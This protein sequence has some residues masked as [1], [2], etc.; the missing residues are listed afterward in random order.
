MLNLPVVV[1]KKKTIDPVPIEL[2]DEPTYLKVKS[3]QPVKLIPGGPAVHVKLQWNG[4]ESLIRGN[5]RAGSS[6]P[7]ASP[8]DLPQDWVR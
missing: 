5:N 3:R 4:K 2:L 6:V 7:A 1:T 8:G